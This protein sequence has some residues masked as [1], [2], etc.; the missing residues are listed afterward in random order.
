MSRAGRET[1]P[2]SNY[3]MA[4]GYVRLYVVKDLFMRFFTQFVKFFSVYYALLNGFF[5]VNLHLE[6]NVTGCHVTGK[7]SIAFTNV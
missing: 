3:I 6:S 1:P 5:F 7:F 2:G 4:T